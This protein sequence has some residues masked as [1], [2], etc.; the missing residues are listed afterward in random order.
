MTTATATSKVTAANAYDVYVEACQAAEAAAAACIPTPMIVGNPKALFGPGSN[1]IDYTQ[2]TYYVP[3]G[4][5]GNASVRIR[6]ARG[7][8]VAMLKKRR[9]GYSN[10]YSGGFEVPAWQ[11]A[12][13]IRGSQ[14]YEIACAAAKAAAGVLEKYGVTCYVDS[15]LD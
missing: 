13:S 10:S 5:C 15:R 11:F 4:V 2:K 12:G 1:E 3:S 9:V 8:L 14:S 7:P 6:P